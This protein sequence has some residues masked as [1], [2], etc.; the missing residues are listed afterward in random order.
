MFSSVI[1]HDRLTLGTQSFSSL[2]GVERPSSV[3]LY[4]GSSTKYT[5][6]ILRLNQRAPPVRSIESVMCHV[7]SPNRAHCFHSVSST[8]RHQ[9]SPGSWLGIG[10]PR[11]I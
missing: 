6:S 11:S 9:A 1:C 5:L 7:S 4:R 8:D 10:L 3:G 2:L